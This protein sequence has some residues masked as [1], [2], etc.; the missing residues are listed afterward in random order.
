MTNE[1][2]HIKPEWAEGP[3]YKMIGKPTTQILPCVTNYNNPEKT[4]IFSIYLNLDSSTIATKEKSG[5]VEE[6]EK[7]KIKGIQLKFNVVKL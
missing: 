2:K 5:D 3:G 6:K 7:K 4:N 1:I